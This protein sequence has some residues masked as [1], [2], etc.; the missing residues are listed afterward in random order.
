[1]E[2]EVE[3]EVSNVDAKNLKFTRDLRLFGDGA[4]ARRWRSV[5]VVESMALVP[6]P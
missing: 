2:V 1:M 4:Y 5:R 3:D 6:V